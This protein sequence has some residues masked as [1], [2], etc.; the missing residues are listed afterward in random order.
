[1]KTHVWNHNSEKI[2]LSLELFYIKIGYKFLLLWTGVIWKNEAC[3]SL[4]IILKLFHNRKSLFSIARE[5]FESWIRKFKWTVAVLPSYSRYTRLFILKCF[6]FCDSLNAALPIFEQRFNVTQFVRLLHL[7]QLEASRDDSVASKA[8][9]Q[10]ICDDMVTA[11][12]FFGNGFYY[13]INVD[14]DYKNKIWKSHG[15]ETC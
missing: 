5:L 3:R 9:Y 4:E 11:S 7:R 15:F 2:H 6:D 1:M 13:F 14:Y 12:D 8:Y 10:N